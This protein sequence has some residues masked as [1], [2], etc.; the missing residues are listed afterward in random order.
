M[1]IIRRRCGVLVTQRRQQAHQIFGP[2]VNFA[3]AIDDATGCRKRKFLA[4]ASASSEWRKRRDTGPPTELEVRLLGQVFAALRQ[5]V[6]GYR[7]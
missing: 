5:L 4:A 2:T 3:A 6:V 1:W 7:R